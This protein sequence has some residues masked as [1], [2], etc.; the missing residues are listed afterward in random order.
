MPLS[1]TQKS[2]LLRSLMLGIQNGNLTAK[3]TYM[4][5]LSQYFGKDEEFKQIA[6]Q[7]TNFMA[8]LVTELFG[9]E[10]HYLRSQHEH[11]MPAFLSI[12]RCKL[13]AVKDGTENI[14]DVIQKV[15]E[16]M[17]VELWLDEGDGYVLLGGILSND[18]LVSLL[19]KKSPGWRLAPDMESVGKII[20]F[21]MIQLTRSTQIRN[22]GSQSNLGH[23][24]NRVQD[25]LNM[26][27][28]CDDKLRRLINGSDAIGTII[29]ALKHRMSR[30]KAVEFLESLAKRDRDN[31]TKD[32]SR[33]R[34]LLT[35][36]IELG[37]KTMKNDKSP[38]FAVFQRDGATN[39]G[40][41]AQPL[42]N[43]RD[44]LRALVPYEYLRKHILEPK[45]FE[46]ISKSIDIHDIIQKRRGDRVEAE[47]A[48]VKCLKALIA[49][50][51]ALEV[52]KTDLIR[53]VLHLHQA[54]NDESG[55]SQWLHMWSDCGTLLE[56]TLM[57]F[58]NKAEKHLIPLDAD[59]KERLERFRR[60]QSSGEGDHRV[61]QTSGM[62]SANEAGA[63]E[64]LS[65]GRPSSDDDDS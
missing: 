48:R 6:L 25:F 61:A 41:G 56:E 22:K 50:P 38:I 18:D 32:G 13:R 28:N 39:N 64:S 34:P 47:I 55:S 52:M 9:T 24:L 4:R 62:G 23:T 44:A 11:V 58:R 36:I 15:L 43:V 14:R 8:T 7:E 10:T 29:R 65:M 54:F 21:E 20:I 31:N 3:G 12:I 33:F 27:Y 1:A 26:L 37:K 35:D 59:V 60:A 42:V 57:E 49:Y 17:C 16:A 63:S 46:I 51:D 45:N 30:V 40:E 5:C 53:P 19:R 2:N